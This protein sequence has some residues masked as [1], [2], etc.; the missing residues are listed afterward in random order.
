M[1]K[2]TKNKKLILI[3]ALIIFVVAV[4][5]W[6]VVTKPVPTKKS[7][8]NVNNERSM[9]YK[10]NTIVEEKDG[11]KI[12]EIKAES[13]NMNTD[14]QEAEMKKIEG[15]YYGEPGKILTVTAPHGLYDAKEKN[16]ILDQGVHAENSDGLSFDAQKMTWN[17]KE[18]LFTGEGNVRIVR[19][20]IQAAGD[21][22]ESSK[23]FSQFKL[24]GHAHII[25]R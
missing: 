1:N 19:A 21:K 16:I 11:K 12:W 5:V 3:Y 18:Q 13:I 22:F 8:Q 17:N 7:A 25:R 10:S 2:L 23:A 20:D 15:K 4:C 6:A 9:D 24:T 14:T